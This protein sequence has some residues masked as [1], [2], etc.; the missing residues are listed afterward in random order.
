[1]TPEIDSDFNPHHTVSRLGSH[2][3]QTPSCA[4]GSDAGAVSYGYGGLVTDDEG[5]VERHDVKLKGVEL[6]KKM[7][8][9][10]KV[11]CIQSLFNTDT[12]LT[13]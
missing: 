12:R 5:L 1:M 11:C 6:E 4:T 7:A 2:V 9:R 8:S 13:F 3:D 10:Y